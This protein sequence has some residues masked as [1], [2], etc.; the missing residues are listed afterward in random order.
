VKNCFVVQVVHPE[1]RG[2]FVVLIK[3]TFFVL[4]FTLCC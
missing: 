1:K 4:S 3:K 2:F